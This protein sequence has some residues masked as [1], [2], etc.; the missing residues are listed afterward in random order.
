MIFIPL[1][2]EDGSTICEYIRSTHEG[3]SGPVF[4]SLHRLEELHMSMSRKVVFEA[5]SK[6]SKYERSV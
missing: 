6:A 3:Y 1:T 5:L 4:V 2:A